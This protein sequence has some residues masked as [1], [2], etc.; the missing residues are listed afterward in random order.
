MSYVSDVL[1]LV[2]RRN[3]DEPEFFQATEEVLTSIEPAI[4]RHP[5]YQEAKLLERLV[6][7]ERVIMFRVSWRMIKANIASIEVLGFK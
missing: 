3:P 7:P 1:N 6:E 4:K 2:K 5:K